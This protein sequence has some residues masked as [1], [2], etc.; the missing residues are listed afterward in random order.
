MKKRR[1]G[2]TGV[3][4]SEIGYGAWGIGGSQWMGAKDEES[5]LA[6]NR[7][8]DLGLNFIDTA[9]ASGDGHSEKL[10]GQLVRDR[11]GDEIYVATKIPPANQDWPAKKGVPASVVFPAAYIRESCEKSLRNLKVERLDLLQLHVW[12]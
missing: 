3:N 12:R 9:L 2:R 6:L 10:V 1:F 4:I 5:L 7:A 8:V 11:K